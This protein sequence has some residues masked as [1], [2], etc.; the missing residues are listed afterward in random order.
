MRIKR[1]FFA[2]LIAGAFLCL[3][4]TGEAQRK[5]SRPP[6]VKRQGMLVTM[7]FK[8]VDIEDLVKTIAKLTGKNF[9]IDDRVRGKVTIISPTPISI[10][11]AYRVFLAAL[12]FRGFMIVPLGK[13]LK[14]VPNQNAIKN[15]TELTSGRST[16]PPV[17]L[18]GAV[19]NDQ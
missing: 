3:P 6:E 12:E 13:L 10:P 16:L 4:N 17:D 11:E 15:P 19:T 14:I 18:R 1:A 7:D 5:S 8:D 2:A 9:M